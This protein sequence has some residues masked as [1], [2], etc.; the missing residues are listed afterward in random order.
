MWMAEPWLPLQGKWWQWF[1]LPCVMPFT[2]A[3]VANVYTPLF[4][5]NGR[6]WECIY[7]TEERCSF[8]KVEQTQLSAADSRWQEKPVT[9]TPTTEAYILNCVQK[10]SCVWG[11]SLCVCVSDSREAIEW[12]SLH[13]L[14]TETKLSLSRLKSLS[15]GNPRTS[16][17]SSCSVYLRG[18]FR[19]TLSMNGFAKECT[20]QSNKTILFWKRLQNCMLKAAS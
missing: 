2:D 12:R 10:C 6:W 14:F 11:K 13:G 18:S 5:V 8:F 1:P 4:C 9:L 17:H 19:S 16:A 3:K 7:G 20:K 15:S